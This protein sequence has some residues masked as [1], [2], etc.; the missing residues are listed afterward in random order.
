MVNPNWIFYIQES[1]FSMSSILNRVQFLDV[2]Y[3]YP[4]SDY[5]TPM[6]TVGMCLT[7]CLW[8]N[9]SQTKC[10]VWVVCYLFIVIMT[11]K[12]VTSFT[13]NS[14]LG[15]EIQ[16]NYVWKDTTPHQSRLRLTKKMPPTSSHGTNLYSGD[17]I[18]S[19]LGPQ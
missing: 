14:D 3:N 6:T 4:I 10:V 13:R 16:I 19:D 8:A 11:G 15:K 1:S 2:L 12:S 18:V 5:M 9:F 17:C 7:V